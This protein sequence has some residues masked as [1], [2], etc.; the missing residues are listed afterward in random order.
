MVATPKMPHLMRK[1][2]NVGVAGCGG[3]ANGRHIPALKATNST[4]LVSVYDHHWPNAEKSAEDHNIPKKFD[5]YTTF[6]DSDL[7]L[8][9][10]STP[11]FTHAEVA[12]QAL[13]SGV[14]VLCE[15]P[16]A[17]ELEDARRMMSVAEEADGEL[18]FVHNFLYSKSVN[19]IR[20]AVRLGKYGKVQ[21]VKGIQFSSIRR[22]LPSWYT[23][24]PGG[25]FFDES[26]HLLYLIEHFIGGLDVL[27]ATSR[28]QK[29]SSQPVRSVNAR[30]EGNDGREGDLSMIFDAPLSEWFFIV[31]GTERIGVV[32]LFRDIKL[33]FGKERDH[34]APQVLYNALSGLVQAS[35]GIISSGVRTIKGDLFFGYNKLLQ[36]YVNFLYGYSE[37]PVPPEKAYNILQGSHTILEKANI[38]Q[39]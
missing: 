6:L 28:S 34:S 35:Y 5:D 36:H 25:L 20:K 23:D 17:V 19:K 10:I 13:E 18:C 31:V 39:R 7:D 2:L 15:K 16:M 32:D 1:P 4:N 27:S 9:T 29:K 14:N 26:P 33:E 3:I 37:N 38:K 8:V 24:L 22:N 30:F 11:P 12:I 21:Y